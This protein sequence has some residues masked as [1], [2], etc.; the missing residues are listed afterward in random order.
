[1]S[2]E[3]ALIAAT[4]DDA[5][6]LS[7][8]FD[9]SAPE[10]LRSIAWLFGLDAPD[11]ASARVLELGCA[12]GGNLI[13][14]AQRHP[15]AQ[16]V[17]VDLSA[18]QVSEGNAVIARLALDNIRLEQRDLATIDAGFGRFDYIVCHGVYSWVP[19]EVRESILRICRQNL[20]PEGVA[21]V[22]YNTYPGWKTREIVRD[23][24]RLHGDGRGAP[25]EQLAHARGMLDFLRE[26]ATGDALMRQILA[27]FGEEVAR[28][29]D[30]YLVHEYLERH[31]QPCYFRDF[32]NAARRQGLGYLADTQVSSMFVSNL[33]Q[34]AAEA[35][36]SVCSEQVALEQYLDFVRNRQFRKTLLTHV[37]REA[38]MTRTLDPARLRELFYIGRFSDARAVEGAPEKRD[39]LTHRGGRVELAGEVTLGVAQA[40]TAAYPNALDG[41]ALAA[42]LRRSGVGE[43]VDLEAEIA[44]VLGQLI[45]FNG[46]DFQR[47]PW[48]DSPAKVPAKPTA[49]APARAWH[50]HRFDVPGAPSRRWVVAPNHETVVLD[51]AAQQL[52]PLLDGRNTHAQ[53]GKA[54]VAAHERG[55]ISLVREEAGSQV[56]LTEAAAVKQCARDVVASTLENLRLRR[57]LVA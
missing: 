52:L 13:P 24:M 17:G 4:Y 21:F 33:G 36:R 32:A 10:N 37:E 41:R 38:A 42:A 7:M 18:A 53:L 6:Y 9:F 54:L 46:V 15:G 40:L 48:I 35:L 26:R 27:T 8:S 5:P 56:R 57:L 39:F 29:D 25:L 16:A 31:N 23:A 51:P 14:F 50:A 12:A 2:N 55:D 1:M 20:S 19:D 22:S 47:A 44:G 11:P 49:W 28:A 43:G 34:E 3:N 30:Y 45:A